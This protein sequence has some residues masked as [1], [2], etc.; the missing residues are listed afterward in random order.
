MVAVAKTVDRRSVGLC[1]AIHHVFR[2][3]GFTLIEM[4]VTLS[5]LTVLLLLAMPAFTE[6]IASQRV[7]IAATDLFTSLLRT[8]SEA[9]KQNSDVTLSPAGAWTDGWVVEAAGQQ[10]DSHGA[11][12]KIA[13]A[14]NVASVTYRSSG[15]V[16]G[17]PAPKFEFSS[18]QT[19]IKR[20]IQIDLSGRPAVT[21]SVCPP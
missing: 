15:R 10:I 19:A 2:D 21:R 20:C 13:I 9:I 16:S 11:T 6:L 8:R 18:T 7:Q 1:P 17:A 5:V 12:S 3:R 14:P 4:L